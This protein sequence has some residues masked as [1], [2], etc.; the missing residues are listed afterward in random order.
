MRWGF[1]WARGPFQMLD[2]IGPARVAERLRHEN[3]D[4]PPL[5]D[6]AAGSS[7]FY[8]NDEGE[9]L[10]VDGLYRPVPVE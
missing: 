10:A 3:R 9:Y 5:L 8:R 4:V 1:N 2:A 7:G 6:L